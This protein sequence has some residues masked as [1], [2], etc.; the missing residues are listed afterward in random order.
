MILW[1]NIIIPILWKYRTYLLIIKFWNT[2]PIAKSSN[3]KMK[4]Q[5]ASSDLHLPSLDLN[6]HLLHT[7]T[8]SRP[9]PS[10]DL[11]LYLL[12]TFTF[13]RHSPSP[14]FH[15]LH[16]FT[17]FRPS[18]LHSSDIHLLH[19]FSFSRPLH[20]SDLHLLQTFTFFRPSPSDLHLHLL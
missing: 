10:S 8:F 9:L 11:Q 2:T 5:L 13:F 12:Q 17:F 6:L 19:T 1:N 20:S 7:F 4:L 15:Y 14:H 18:P 16:T 3:W